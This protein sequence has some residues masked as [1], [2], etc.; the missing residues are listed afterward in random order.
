MFRPVRHMLNT[1]V[2]ALDSA[3]RQALD[4]M[5]T[6]RSFLADRFDERKFKMGKDDP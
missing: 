6:E 2:Q 3:Q 4:H 1:G 5:A